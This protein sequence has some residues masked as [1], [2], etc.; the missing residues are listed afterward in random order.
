M[1][2]IFYV[3]GRSEYVLLCG[4]CI[5]KHDTDCEFRDMSALPPMRASLRGSYQPQLPLKK[6]LSISDLAG[7]VE[8]D[9][10]EEIVNFGCKNFCLFWFAVLV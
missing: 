5:G 2:F 6:S 8:E 4:T 3:G 7:E 9:D 10:E 1:V